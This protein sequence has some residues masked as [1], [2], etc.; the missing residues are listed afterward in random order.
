MIRL[1]TVTGLPVVLSGRM[2]GRVEQTVL[3]PDGHTL[4]GLVVRHGLGGAKW[5]DSG[6]IRVL[7]DVSVIISDKPG[8]LPKDADFTLSS[9]K[10]TG[11]LNLGRVTDVY[12]NPQTFQVTALEITLGLMEEWTCGRMLARDFVVRPAPQEPGQVLIPCGCALE[13]TNRD[14]REVE[15]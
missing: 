13:R 3:T 7:G 10:D 8:H 5:V 6:C 2:M 4:R 1:G 12:L 11:G 14:R 9:V 15:V